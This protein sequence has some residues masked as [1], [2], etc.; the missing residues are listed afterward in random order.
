[1]F[2]FFFASILM[3]GLPA[4][5]VPD[6]STPYHYA[7]DGLFHAWMAQRVDEGWL[8]NNA[9]SGYPFGSSFLD[10][11]G[12]DGASHLAIK[13]LA[14]LGG[15][16]VAGTNLFFLLGFPVCFIA[17][18][19]TG[20]AFGLNRSFALAAGLLYSF[21]PFHFLRVHHLFYTWYF[22][23]PVFFGL[24]LGVYRTGLNAPS[25]GQ[26]PK[27]GKLAARV[28]GLV[29]LASFGVY[30][31]LFGVIVMAVAGVL[32]WARTQ[33]LRGVGKA[34]ALCAVVALG[35]LANVA[36]NLVNNL[37]EGR[38][39]EVAK[40]SVVE[41]EYYGLKMMQLLLPRPE[42]RSSTLAEVGQAY[43][44]ATPLINENS[45]SS[46]GLIGAAGFLLALLYVV[47]SPKG[48]LADERLRLLAATTLVL[49][50]FAT[51]GGLG[52]LFAMLVSPSI[53]G[54]NR[55]SVFI[56][57]AAILFLFLA[58]ELVMRRFAPRLLRYPAAVAAAMLLFG[59]YDQ[60]NP[61]CL[62]CNQL[63]KRAFES[64]RDFVQAIEQAVPKGAAIYQLPYIGFPETPP[65][66]RLLN[67][68]MMAGVLH[69]NELHW[70]FGGMKGRPGDL[71]YRSLAQEP[72]AKQIEV[73]RNLGFEGI[74]IDRR[75]YADNAEALISELSS[76]LQSA[77]ALQSAD[78]ELV[79]FKL[80]GSKHPQLEN[81]P[82]LDIMQ[83]ADYHADALGVRYPGT[84][85]AGIDFTKGRWPDFV[86]GVTGVS[87]FE[88]WGLWSEGSRVKFDFNRTLPHR[89]TLVLD[90]QA[91][92]TN[93]GQPIRVEIGTKTYS[94]VLNS[95]VAQVR[96]D[97]DLG[98]DEA[99]SITFI[100]PHP[101]SPKEISGSGDERRLGIG[102]VS[103]RIIE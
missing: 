38:N 35:V 23:A 61:A 90:A 101:V 39:P 57:F 64:D 84:L 24:A 31:A 96:I 62:S 21:L 71:F 15:G 8:F 19:A 12:S 85:D 47:F 88:P 81:K 50:L 14:M 4:G 45:T 79:F 75:G 5:L 29:A 46:L 58:L 82:A 32:N 2:S 89:F 99:S 103:L 87:R 54:W 102:F 59:L 56:A 51:I 70:S 63:N 48:V 73:V 86:S 30:Y 3:S 78:G 44:S 80:A 20:R 83:Q 11:P 42:H 28:L 36:P 100:P 93:A 16:W 69:S 1:M 55:L 67:Y 91:Y 66:H 49:F 6:L 40:R 43:N 34:I 37:S 9:R 68:Q 41:S 52:S 60:T 33:Q 10:Y 25:E 94:I 98:R 18:F 13:C 7:S 95:G 65:L 27:L 97:V 74:T 17:A 92:A 22:V 53:R 26:G 76:R 72:M 77:P